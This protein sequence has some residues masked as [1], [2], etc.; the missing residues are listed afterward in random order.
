M[1]EEELPIVRVRTQTLPGKR[2]SPQHRDQGRMGPG[3]EL[4]DSPSPTAVPQV[5]PS[6]GSHLFTP[7]LPTRA[8]PSSR[9]G[10]GNCTLGHR[11]AEHQRGDHVLP[12]P[13]SRTGSLRLGAKRLKTPLATGK[14]RLE[15]QTRTPQGSIAEQNSTGLSGATVCKTPPP[16]ITQ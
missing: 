10:A 3:W 7:R 6:Q 2:C 12:T 16:A 5:S 11:T 4:W 1:E 8:D 14:P 9:A 13:P 15:L